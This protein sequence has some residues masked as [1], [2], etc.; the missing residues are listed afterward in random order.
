M[1]LEDAPGLSEHSSEVHQAEDRVGG[2]ADVSVKRDARCHPSSCFHAN[3]F[4]LLNQH[5]GIS[6]DTT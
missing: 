6:G 2:A 4:F 5:L 1:S 3:Q